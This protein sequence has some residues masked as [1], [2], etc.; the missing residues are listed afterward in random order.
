[1]VKNKKGGSGHK[2]MARKNVAPKGG[3]NKKLRK[4]VE[5]GEMYARVTAMLGGGHARIICAD[6][7]ERTLVVRGKFRGRNKRDNTLKLNTFVL[8][9][10]QS[11]SFGAVIQKGKL[12][13]A[14]LLEVY[15]EG[16]KEELIKLPGMDKILDDESKVK[17]QEDLGFDVMTASETFMEEVI[18]EEDKAR[19]KHNKKIEKERKKMAKKVVEQDK[20]EDKK[21]EFDME[22]DWDDI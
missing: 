13:K 9:G 20:V 21:I 14:D 15:K 16:Q 11:V 4:A 2:K 19:L 8:V 12:E 10:L 1:M 5:E 17:Q 7:K 18:S 22:L 3:Y 6:G